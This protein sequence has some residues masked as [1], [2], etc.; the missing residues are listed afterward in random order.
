MIFKKLQLKDYFPFLA[1]SGANPTLDIYLPDEVM[2]RPDFKRPS[3]LICPGG[4]YAMCSPREAEPIALHLLPEGFN[5]FILWYTCAPAKFPTQI[6]EVAAAMELIYKNAEEWKCDTDKISIMGF[7][8]GGHL[9][10]HY[11]TMFDC[12]EVRELFPE[13]KAP[14]G[15]VLCYPVITATKGKCHQGS[16]QNLVG[17]YPLTEDEM[18]YFSLEYCVKENTPPAFIWHTAEDTCV[19]VYSS[20]A[21]ATALSEHKIPFELKI[22]PHGTHG[23]ATSDN[24]TVTSNERFC[25]YNHQW[26]SEAKKWLKYMNL[27]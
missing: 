1:E 26:L 7:S 18:R 17:H 27:A 12:K 8:A 5:V 14:N 23:L 21:Y 13:S 24:Q 4:G 9:A 22:F 19:P 3:M 15:A 2:N 25:A 10:G 11:S 6:R 16:F 20:L